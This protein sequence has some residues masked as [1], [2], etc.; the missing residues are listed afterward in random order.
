MSNTKGARAC[1]KCGDWCRIGVMV[2]CYDLMVCR[3][4]A[5][6]S[7]ALHKQPGKGIRA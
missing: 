6:E 3:N 7:P 5:Q 1:D 4:C 2:P